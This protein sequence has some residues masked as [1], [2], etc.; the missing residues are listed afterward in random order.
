MMNRKSIRI[1]TTLVL[2]AAIVT[3]FGAEARAASNGGRSTP[4]TTV[5]SRALK[6]GAGPMTGEPDWPNG[7]PLPPKDGAYPTG[8]KGRPDMWALRYRQLVRIWLGSVPRHLF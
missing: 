8:G 3:A 7:S 2:A 6:P 4:V 1:L 5:A